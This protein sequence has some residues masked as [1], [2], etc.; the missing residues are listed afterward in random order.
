ITEGDCTAPLASTT[1]AASGSGTTFGVT[2]Q[3]AGGACLDAIPGTHRATYFPALE[4]P[5]PPCFASDATTLTLDLAGVLIVLD[6]A[7]VA[8]RF[9][10]GDTLTDGLIRGFLTETNAE[11]IPLPEALPLVGG[12]PLASILR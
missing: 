3:D 7:R 8:A 9:G 6:D 10:D 5:S 4:T 1:C 2:Y 12:Q 11:A